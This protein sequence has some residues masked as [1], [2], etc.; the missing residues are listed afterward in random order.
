MKAGTRMVPLECGLIFLVVG[1]ACFGGI[2]SREAGYLAWI[3][4]ANAI[5]LSMF[6]RFPHMARPAGWVAAG[7][8]FLAVDAALGTSWPANLLL[9][10][11]NLS[12]IAVGYWIYMRYPP[13]IRLLQRPTS[14][15]LLVGVSL[16]AGFVT[17]ALGA[18]VS[19][20]L[21]GKTYLWAFAM[22]SSSQITNYLALMPFILTL[23]AWKYK[24]LGLQ[25]LVARAMSRRYANL[26]IWAAFLGS[27]ALG[28]VMDGPGAVMLPV[29]ALLWMALAFP[30]FTTAS[31]V[32][33]YVLWS[34]AAMSMGII[35]VGVNLQDAKSVISL[36]L[37]LTLLALGPLA[38]ASTNA[39]RTKLLQELQ[40]MATYDSLTGIFGRAAFLREGADML[41]R[42]PTVLLLMDIDH[43]KSINDRFGHHAGDA[44]LL[45]FCQAV[46]SEL[47]Q[48]DLFGRLGG[49]EFAILSSSASQQDALA[50]AQR[51]CRKVEETV[52]VTDD[53]VSLRMTVSIGVVTAS[54]TVPQRL[55]ELLRRADELLYQAKAA[56]RNQ[57]KLAPVAQSS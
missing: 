4:P 20:M 6:V 41:T 54:P 57:V 22:W 52:I 37:G 56:G 53:G 51:I 21:F 15:L 10:L 36:R 26:G 45:G 44:A 46:G 35:D 14:A 40:R 47:S 2:L 29:P 55:A 32:L 17:S 28:V 31:I 27:C 13:D 16:A 43:F 8:A 3:W 25:S 49:E 34:Q 5:L 24:S 50:L 30:L 39:S 11:S 19:V 18:V 12:G 1:L 42:S 33:A 48:T 7:V 9:N 38:V 23:P